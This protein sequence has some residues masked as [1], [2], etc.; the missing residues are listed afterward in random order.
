MCPARLYRLGLTGRLVLFRN[1]LQ[2]CAPFVRG[3][4]PEQVVS[5]HV[6]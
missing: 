1:L 3:N 2:K 4:Q 5:Q 6:V